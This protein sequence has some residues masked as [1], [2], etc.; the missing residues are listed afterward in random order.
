MGYKFN[1]D[2]VDENKDKEKWNP[3]RHIMIGGW[4]QL[5]KLYKSLLKYSKINNKRNLMKKTREYH[6]LINTR[7][8]ERA[9]EI[10]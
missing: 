10:K 9:N 4:E 1:K 7:L 6:Y 2:Y 8:P 3:T 5:S